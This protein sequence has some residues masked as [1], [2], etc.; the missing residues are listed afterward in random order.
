MERAL[1]ALMLGVIPGVSQAQA[2]ILALDIE[3]ECRSISES[4]LSECKCQGLYFE[5]KFGPDEGA[6]A[7]H[8]VGRS[9]ASQPQVAVTSL[10]DRFGAA[11]LDKVAR[12]IVETRGEVAFYCPLSPNLAD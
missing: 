6:A 11:N 2:T 12:R 3:A 1:L 7:L 5:S 8:L 10:Y 4:E 9:Y